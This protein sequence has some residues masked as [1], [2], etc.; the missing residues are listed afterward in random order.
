MLEAVE[1]DGLFHELEVLRVA[2]EEVSGDSVAV[3]VEEVVHQRAQLFGGLAEHRCLRASQG[4]RQ[5]FFAALEALEREPEHRL[6]GAVDAGVVLPM[7]SDNL[8]L[9][10][11]D[12]GSHDAAHLTHILPEVFPLGVGAIADTELL[13]QWVEH[14]G[15]RRPSTKFGGGGVIG[16]VEGIARLPEHFLRD[17][18][19]HCGVVDAGVLAGVMLSSLCFRLLELLPGILRVLRAC[20]RL[21]KFLLSRLLRFLGRLRLRGSADR[22]GLFQVFRDGLSRQRGRAE[23]GS[24]ARNIIFEGCHRGHA[25]AVSLLH[26]GDERLFE[27]LE[28]RGRVIEALECIAGGVLLRGLLDA[29]LESFEHDPCVRLEAFGGVHRPIVGLSV[30]SGRLLVGHAIFVLRLALPS[31]VSMPVRLPIHE[32]VGDDLACGRFRLE[33]G[34]HRVVD[35]ATGGKHPHCFEEVRDRGPSVRGVQDPC[36]D[37]AVAAGKCATR[38]LPNI[39]KHGI[40]KVV[41]GLE[42]VPREERDHGIINVDADF[43]P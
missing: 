6:V 9:Y 23:L 17:V 43:D 40:G 5:C 30:R 20:S 32:G 7:Y 28:D 37:G 12:V 2:K 19:N 13:R 42:D 15:E 21:G 22:Y 26:G 35:S 11:L 38:P 25:R 1:V 33:H 10:A 18:V 29:L 41:Y 24:H 34:R 39:I 31:R 16:D 3:D 14:A 4:L 36:R 27:T 8:P